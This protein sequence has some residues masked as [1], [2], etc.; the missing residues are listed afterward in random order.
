MQA[1][2]LSVF[3]CCCPSFLFLPILD[4]SVCPLLSS[5]AEGQG[6]VEGS[7]AWGGGEVRLYGWGKDS[8]RFL[9]LYNHCHLE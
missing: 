1:S 5:K 6:G 8:L 7:T 4:F 3:L 2:T 9:V